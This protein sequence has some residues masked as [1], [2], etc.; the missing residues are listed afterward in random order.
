MTVVQERQ[1]Q[2]SNR[3]RSSLPRPPISLILSGATALLLGTAFLAD[4]LTTRVL[5]V[6][7][8]DFSASARNRLAATNQLVCRSSIFSL[9]PND[10]FVQIHYAD[11]PEL[12]HNQIVRSNF[13]LF[14]KCQST[15]FPSIGRVLG[16]SFPLAVDRALLEIQ[17]KRSQGNTKPVV[18]VFT[19]DAAEP[20]P[21]Q[22]IYDWQHLRRQLEAIA[23]DRGVVVILGPTG[24]LQ[25]DLAMQFQGVVRLAICP[26]T[27]AQNCLE[28]AF[29]RARRL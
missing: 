29:S 19:L 11:F 10:E 23:S 20:G 21:G 8:L 22:P 2:R 18:A 6:Q 3:P 16:T 26:N 4:F 12:L 25:G 17:H 5:L 7:T 13:S 28:E 14:E 27:D 1:N 24:S 9:K 15:A